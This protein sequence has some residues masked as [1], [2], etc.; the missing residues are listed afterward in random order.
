LKR[1]KTDAKLPPRLLF[2]NF[3]PEILD[4]RRTGLNQYLHDLLKDEYVLVLIY[5]FLNK[6]T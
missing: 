1:T 3:K 6:S 4:K 5:F 2:G